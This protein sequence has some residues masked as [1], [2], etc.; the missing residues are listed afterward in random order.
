MVVGS[1]SWSHSDC[2]GRGV[3]RLQ[4]RGARALGI[5][6]IGVSTVL[7]IAKISS[8]ALVARSA[9]DHDSGGG[10]ILPQQV[11]RFS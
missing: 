7:A 6:G 11:P 5:D 2:A 8:D 3:E 9:C 10:P 1:S 4:Q